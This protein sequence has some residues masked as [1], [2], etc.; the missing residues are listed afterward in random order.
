M[1]PWF[2]RALAAA[3]LKE[4]PVAQLSNH[5]A[6]A[7]ATPYRL[8]VPEGTSV[9]LVSRKIPRYFVDASAA[10]ALRTGMVSVAHRRRP[11]AAKMP[12]VRRR[13]NRILRFMA[14]PVL[15]GQ[16]RGAILRAGRIPRNHEGRS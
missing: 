5:I 13:T 2:H 15:V 8:T 16:R 4:L 1:T 10:D 7:G 6:L 12:A 11:A 9:G 14:P 3:A